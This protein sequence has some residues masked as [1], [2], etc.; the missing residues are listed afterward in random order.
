[1]RRKRRTNY[2]RQQKK[3]KTIV[4]LALAATILLLLI[5]CNVLLKSRSTGVA[6]PIS[7]PTP[8]KTPPATTVPTQ[9]PIPT[10]TPTSPPSSSPNSTPTVNATS[11][12][13]YDSNAFKGSLFIGD[14]RTEGL[15]LNTGLK[16]ATFYYSRG[17]T[18]STIETSKIAKLK[19]GSKGTVLEALKE[20]NF[21]KIYISLGINELGWPYVHTFISKYSDLITKIQKEQPQ[22]KIYVQSILPVSKE[23]SDRSKI[24]NN[25]NINKFNHSIE[26]MCK[27]LNVTYLTPNE[28]V[29]NEKKELPSDAAPDGIHLNRTYCEK[30]LSYL[31]KHS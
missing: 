18:V 6:A 11:S 23:V 26:E 14:S 10:L 20:N 7:T 22:A 21:E 24:Y 19:S 15:H 5:L 25:T 27:D 9:T 16:T 29:W 30:W 1:M 31:A 28:A 2:G 4:T 12:A 17:L 8:T 3:K 13:T